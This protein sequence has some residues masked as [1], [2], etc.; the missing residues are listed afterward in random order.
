MLKTQT[1]VCDTDIV[2]GKEEG[3]RE[4]K[5][6]VLAGVVWFYIFRVM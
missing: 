1:H 2:S 4:G 6:S 5:F 3:A